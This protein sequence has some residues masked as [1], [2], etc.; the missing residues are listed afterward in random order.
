VDLTDIKSI[1]LEVESV[2]LD[3]IADATI[4]HVVLCAKTTDNA[5]E[6]D[7]AA[8]VELTAGGVQTFTLDVSTLSGP[9]YVGLQ[10]SNHNG[11][12]VVIRSFR[13]ER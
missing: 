2:T 1:I 13:M 10:I 5:D 11:A 12:K 6:N 7:V 9:H 4:A 3:P 8:S